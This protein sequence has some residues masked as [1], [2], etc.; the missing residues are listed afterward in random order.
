MTS[1]IK[2]KTENPVGRKCGTATFEWLVYRLLKGLKDTAMYTFIMLT[3]NSV[4]FLD[5]LV[6]PKSCMFSA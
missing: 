3:V 2:N 1:D 4:T 6:H 5:L